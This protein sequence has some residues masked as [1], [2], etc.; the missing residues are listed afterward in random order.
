LGTD[1]EWISSPEDSIEYYISGGRNPK[2]GSSIN[3]PYFLPGYFNPTY[4][5]PGTPRYSAAQGGTVPYS[6]AEGGDV[7]PRQFNLGP[8]MEPQIYPQ[9]YPQDVPL[10]SVNVDP[11]AESK[12]YY[13]SLLAPPAA[14]RSTE[15]LES[16][17]TKLD[18]D[19]KKPKY[20]DSGFL[21]KEDAGN[22]GNTGSTG[23]TGGGGGLPAGA[24]PR[25]IGGLPTGTAVYDFDGNL[26]DTG[27][28]DGLTTKSW[29][30]K[31]LDNKLA[32]RTA[33]DARAAAALVRNKDIA[34]GGSTGSGTGRR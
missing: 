17:L 3:E 15:N 20:Y 34:T 6:Y 30:Q 13:E 1:E 2:Y 22:T 9:T 14:P 33:S 7:D 23:S 5:P 28:I 25:T 31:G 8:P 27:Y 26:I 24:R 10:K 11:R 12:K 19:V 29:W 16:F 32:N 21:T 18:A 4:K